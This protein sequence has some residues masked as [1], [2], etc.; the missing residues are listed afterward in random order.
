MMKHNLL[1]TNVL[2]IETT[3]MT[4]VSVRKIELHCE[5]NKEKL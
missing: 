1:R 2:A 4:F 5:Y 3:A